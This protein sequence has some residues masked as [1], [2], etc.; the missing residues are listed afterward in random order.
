[1]LSSDSVGVSVRRGAL[2]DSVLVNAV[3]LL[4]LECWGSVLLFAVGLAKDSA[5]W[6]C[7]SSWAPR[8]VGD[9]PSASF[10]ETCK[11]PV[12]EDLDF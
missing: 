3:Q 2:Q 4:G 11:V 8:D 9:Q 7:C 6:C 10:A 5:S 1:M 12:A